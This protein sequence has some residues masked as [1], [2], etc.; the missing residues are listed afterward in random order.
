[1]LLVSLSE[2][3]GICVHLV[4]AK[5]AFG[6][7]QYVHVGACESLALL[8]LLFVAGVKIGGGRVIVMIVELGRKPDNDC[9]IGF[10]FDALE[11]RG[12]CL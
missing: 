7:A 5:A 10:R 8:L 11:A 4:Q 6:R 2:E 1:M 12:L 9:R 3:V